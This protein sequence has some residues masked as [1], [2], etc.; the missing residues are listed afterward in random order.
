MK[1]K[2]IYIHFTPKQLLLDPWNKMIEE[3]DGYK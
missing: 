3:S 1:S 2:L